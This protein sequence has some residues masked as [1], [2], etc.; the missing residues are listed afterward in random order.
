[1]D[2][3]PP[4]TDTIGALVAQLAEISIEQWHEEDRTRLPD[5]H[6]VAEAKRKI[7][8]LN[9]RRTNLIE[10]IDEVV[11]ELADQLRASTSS[12]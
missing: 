11:L 3:N 12:G 1:M 8:R 5:D 4:M 7:D 2:K 9:Q 10:R 6:I